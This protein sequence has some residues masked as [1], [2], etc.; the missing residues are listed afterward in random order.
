[1]NAD[2][3]TPGLPLLEVLESLPAGA[4]DDVLALAE[5]EGRPLD[6]LLTQVLLEGLEATGRLDRLRQAHNLPPD[7][8]YTELE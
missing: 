1:V 8:P 6:E 3:Q 5:P 2:D 4:I 7:W